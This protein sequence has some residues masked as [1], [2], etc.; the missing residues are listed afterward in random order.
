[1]GTVI[2]LTGQRFGR[3]KVLSYAGK[4]NG[5]GHKLYF[6][7]CDCGKR[8]T[9]RGN[10]LIKGVI[11]SCGC[12][13][14]EIT[15]KRNTTHGMAAH[16]GTNKQE[17]LYKCWIDMK[18]RC[19]NPKNKEWKN[20][21]G[22]GISV[23]NEWQEFIPFRDWALANGYREDLTLDRIN[24]NGDY[25]PENCRWATLKEQASNRRKTA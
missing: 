9:I 3:L 15:I 10:S 6:C 23:C 11:V 18:H 2:D 4:E 14:R 5:H 17:R 24:V 20:Y 21:G 8:K 25:C 19:R 12:H 22:R 16:S 13:K 1:M 7:E